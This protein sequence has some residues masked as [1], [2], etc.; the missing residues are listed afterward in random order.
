MIPSD[1]SSDGGSRMKPREAPC[2]DS[3]ARGSSVP[4]FPS[5]TSQH[6]RGVFSN[7]SPARSPSRVLTAV[8]RTGR[9]P[10]CAD[11]SRVR[12]SPATLPSQTFPDPPI[13]CE[14]RGAPRRRARARASTGCR[15]RARFFSSRR[16]RTNSE[17]VRPVLRERSSRSSRGRREQECD[18]ASSPRESRSD[19]FSRYRPERASGGDR[20][21]LPAP[22][23]CRQ[24]SRSGDR[25][26]PARPGSHRLAVASPRAPTL[27]TRANGLI[28][29]C[30]QCTGRVMERT[31]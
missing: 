22:S 30:D 26:P 14:S 15:V 28:N 25:A 13:A 31:G 6:R 19:R 12:I 4:P 16:A 9:E 27:A 2:S 18:R 3:G 20:P 11:R 10:E 24:P 21:E 1:P 8:R 5:G 29:E 23:P 7:G 17:F